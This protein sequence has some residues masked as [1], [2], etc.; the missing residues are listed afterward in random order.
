M[1]SPIHVQNVKSVQNVIQMALKGCFFPEKFARIAHQLFFRKKNCDNCP[2]AGGIT[3][4]R[5]SSNLFS[6]T[7]SSEPTTFKI[8]ITEFLKKQM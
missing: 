6:R 2:G 4:G 3:P 8:V 5:R 7:Q 1:A